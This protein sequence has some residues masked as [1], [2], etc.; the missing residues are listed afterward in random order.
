MVFTVGLNQ[1]KNR[2]N[3][4]ISNEVVTLKNTFDKIRDDLNKLGYEIND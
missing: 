1:L 3:Q 2:L 4:Q